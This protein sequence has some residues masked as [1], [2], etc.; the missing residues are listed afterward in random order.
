MAIWYFLRQLILISYSF[1]TQD[2]RKLLK[3]HGIF[4]VLSAAFNGVLGTSI[5]AP[6]QEFS[7]LAQKID[8]RS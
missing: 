3:M 4:Q 8:G 1:L 5:A 2:K 7:S 6:Q